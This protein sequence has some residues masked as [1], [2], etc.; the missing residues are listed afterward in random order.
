MGALFMDLTQ[1][2]AGA[3]QTV[4]KVLHFFG[5]I[6]TVIERTTDKE[7][8]QCCPIDGKRSGVPGLPTRPD[9][10]QNQANNPQ[11]SAQGVR[12]SREGI[13]E[14]HRIFEAHGA[15]VALRCSIL[16]RAVL[17]SRPPL[18]N[19]KGVLLDEQHAPLELGDA[20]TSDSHRHGFHRHGSPI[21]HEDEPRSQKGYVHP[22][23]SRSSY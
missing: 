5:A 10:E 16:P 17:W 18:F 8:D 20:I 21:P 15:S 19:K 3:I 4:E 6:E 23:C 12:E 9:Q 11:Q 13:F 14:A 2:D 1:V 7:Q 22:C